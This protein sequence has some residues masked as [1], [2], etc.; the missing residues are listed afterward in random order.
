MN[1]FDKLIAQANGQYHRIPPV[2]EYILFWKPIDTETSR[3]VNENGEMFVYTKTANYIGGPEKEYKKKI[4]PNWLTYRYNF[5]YD[6]PD[7][8]EDERIE[9]M[10]KLIIDMPELKQLQGFIWQ[11]HNTS[12]GTRN[13]TDIKQMPEYRNLYIKDDSIY[14]ELKFELT[15]IRKKT[16]DEPYFK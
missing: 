6:D 2:I 5:Y 12:S 11:S 16:V 14:A 7:E 1:K 10:K 9:T 3:V 13:Y 4:D 15:I 8:T